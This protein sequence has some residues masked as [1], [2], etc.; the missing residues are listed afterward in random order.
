MEKILKEVKKLTGNQKLKLYNALQKD[1]YLPDHA[2]KQELTPAEWKK[3]T[4][5]LT[6]MESGK[7]KG[8]SL[9]GHL[10]WLKQRRNAV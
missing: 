5:R 7:A 3:I 4:N 2:A 1:L 6:E 9:N 10:Q 8:I